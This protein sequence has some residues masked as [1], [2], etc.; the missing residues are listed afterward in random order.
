MNSY[1]IFFKSKD[2]ILD[3][4]FWAIKLWKHDKSSD[5]SMERFHG[6]VTVSDSR[7]YDA[8]NLVV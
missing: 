4:H 7:E 8:P 2:F 1:E 5:L 3:I 6:P